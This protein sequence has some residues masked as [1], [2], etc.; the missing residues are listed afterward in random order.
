[1]DLLLK[2][3]SDFSPK[4]IAE[5]TSYVKSLQGTTP[6]APK[7]PQGEQYVEQQDVPDKAT[8]TTENRPIA[9]NNTTAR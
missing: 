5:I 9:E 4:Q 6:A 8:D 3:F 1:M 2:Y 7:E